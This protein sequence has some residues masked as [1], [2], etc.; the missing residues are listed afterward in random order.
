MSDDLTNY[1]WGIFYYNPKDRR[2]LVPKRNKWMGWT[3]NFGNPYS[4]FIVIFIVL[5]AIIMGYIS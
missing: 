3:L 1:K 4:Y 5:I 2:I